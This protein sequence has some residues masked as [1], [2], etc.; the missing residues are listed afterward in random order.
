MI[1]RVV[2]FGGHIQA[3]GLARQVAA[4]RRGLVIGNRKLVIGEQEPKI[5]VVIVTDDGCSVARFSRAVDRTIIEP[6]GNW[7]LVIAHFQHS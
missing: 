3:L 5:E 7:S 2:I 1:Q 4:H 6:I